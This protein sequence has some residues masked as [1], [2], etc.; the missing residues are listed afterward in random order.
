[1]ELVLGLFQQISNG[2]QLP[3]RTASEELFNKI[4]IITGDKYSADFVISYFK[5]VNTHKLFPRPIDPTCKQGVAEERF[6]SPDLVEAIIA[7][8]IKT[9]VNEN[10]ET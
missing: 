2:F 9:P 8:K 6:A 10:I 3:I 1:M 4:N 5:T 7:K